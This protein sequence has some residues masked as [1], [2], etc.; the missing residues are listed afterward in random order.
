LSIRGF[1]CFVFYGLN[2]IFLET[3]NITTIGKG[4]FE[5]CRELR[6]IWT[7]LEREINKLT[8][9]IEHIGDDAFKN[10]GIGTIK[11]P[12]NLKTLG[13]NCLN[14]ATSIVMPSNTKSLPTFTEESSYPFD[15]NKVDISIP[16]KFEN[17]IKDN[18]YWSKYIN[19]INIY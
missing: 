14:S 9:S 4:A 15:I 17:K 11:L 8:D 10:T 12:S 16:N 1:L 3:N 13:N 2:Y 7:S 6:N 5:E 18:K 19:N